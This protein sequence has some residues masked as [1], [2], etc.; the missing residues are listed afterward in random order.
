MEK[1]KTKT[2]RQRRVCFDFEAPTIGIIS[3]ANNPFS[4]P[5]SI[6]KFSAIFE[7]QYEINY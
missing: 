4:P 5:W 6:N 7:P 3:E 2:T 1:G